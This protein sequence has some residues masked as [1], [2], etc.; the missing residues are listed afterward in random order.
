MK[1]IE[2]HTKSI[3]TRTNLPGVQWTVNP[4]LGCTHGCKYCYVPLILQDKRKLPG[5][6][7]SF[8]EV[9]INAP[10]LAMATPQG[11]IMFSTG[12]DPYQEIEKQY[13]L[14]RK[15]LECMCPS[16]NVYILT[17]SPLILRDVDVLSKFTNITVGF[18]FFTTD[19]HTR[20]MA[21]P[22]A[23]PN[24][25]RVEAL[26][27]IKRMGFK[28][29]IHIGPL[30]P[31]LSHIEDLIEVLLPFADSLSYEFLNPKAKGIMERIFPNIPLFPSGGERR[32]IHTLF[33]RLTKPN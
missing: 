11:R 31:S 33:R 25:Q 9:K 7:G 24:E 20:R 10:M 6:W 2:V 3:F 16:A 27:E 18:S 13:A 32:Y 23:P 12:C 28:T 21:E 26:A 4:Y 1:I 15:I 22:N 19:E 8:V 17:K 14:T 29:H 5:E 30:I